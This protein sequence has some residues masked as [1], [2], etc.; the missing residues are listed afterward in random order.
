MLDSL[1]MEVSQLVTKPLQFNALPSTV[2][3]YAALLKRFLCY[4]VRYM[5]QPLGPQEPQRRIALKATP[6]QTNRFQ[7]LRTLIRESRSDPE[8]IEAAVVSTNDV[9]ESPLMHWLAIEGIDTKS[10]TF[11]NP[12]Y[13]TH[14]LSGIIYIMRIILTRHVTPKGEEMDAAKFSAYFGR[15]LMDGSFSVYT[16][17]TNLRA[18]G[19]SIRNQH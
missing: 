4:L 8:A 18:Y 9:Y 13:F 14:K 5:D 10:L 19:M 16:E 6:R 3:E 12:D 17:I 7:T 15:Y 11:I 2:T 1:S